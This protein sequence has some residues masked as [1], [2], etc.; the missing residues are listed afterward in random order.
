MPGAVEISFFEHGQTLADL[1]HEIH[2]I[3][4]RLGFSGDLKAFLLEIELVG[5]VQPVAGEEPCWMPMAGSGFVTLLA[6]DGGAEAGILEGEA[7]FY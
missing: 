5:V 4:G 2:A 1:T 3:Q 7:V 6:G